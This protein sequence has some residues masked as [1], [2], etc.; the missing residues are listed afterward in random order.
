MNIS[1]ILRLCR[2]A[3]ANGVYDVR[4]K[5]SF[6]NIKILYLTVS[7]ECVRCEFD[8][9]SR[10]LLI[11][12]AVFW[13]VA[14]N[15]SWFGVDYVATVAY[16]C[17]CFNL[18]LLFMAAFYSFCKTLQ[19]LSFFSHVLFVLFRNEVAFQ[20]SVTRCVSEMNYILNRMKMLI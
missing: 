17:P 5:Y 14:I 4:V 12:N 13:K 2:N 19:N 6:K 20:R 9:P 10:S 7:A 8:W 15:F 3:T 16:P 11:V 18:L 1:Y